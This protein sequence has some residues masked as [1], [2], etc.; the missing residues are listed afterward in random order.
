MESSHSR[1]FLVNL[2]YFKASFIRIIYSD[3]FCKKGIVKELKKF[4]KINKVAGQ[5][6][7]L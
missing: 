7:N 5:H 1:S 6:V 3:V 2:Q 4:T